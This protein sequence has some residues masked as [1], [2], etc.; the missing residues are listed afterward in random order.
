MPDCHEE[1]SAAVLAAAA[2]PVADDSMIARSKAACTCAL[3]AALGDCAARPASTI[4]CAAEESSLMRLAPVL[5]HAWRR[6]FQTPLAQ[7]AG[8]SRSC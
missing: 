3:D 2:E 8:A 4:A 5:R 6:P 7:P 1:L